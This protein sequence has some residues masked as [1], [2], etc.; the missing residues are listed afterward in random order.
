MTTVIDTPIQPVRG[1]RDHTDYDAAEVRLASNGEF[2]SSIL[3]APQRLHYVSRDKLHTV[4]LPSP[5]GDSRNEAGYDVATVSLGIQAIHQAYAAHIALNLRPDTLWY[6]I[7]HEVAEHVRQNADRYERLFTD[8]PGAKQTITVRDDSLSYDGPSD[9]QRSIKL[10]REPLAAKISDERLNL[11]V[12]TFS[13]STI[14][15]E[16]ALLVALMDTV[17]PYYDFRWETRCGIPQIRL[18]GEPTDWW[19]LHRRAEQLARE[20]GGL[21]GYFKDLMPVL[22]EI[23]QTAGGTEPDQAFWRALYKQDGGSGG[24]YVTGWITAFFAHIQTRD[25]AKPKETFDWRQFENGWGGYK[26]NHF[27]SHVTRVPFVWNYL[28]TEI[29]MAFV[30]GITGVDFDDDFLAP[31]L[32]FAVAE[33]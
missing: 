22:T 9:W 6:F 5:F 1:V 17:S 26:S 11:F 33:V 24:P 13:T 21:D 27:P 19:E 25:G 16:T 18:E 14:E 4:H 12:P 31:R 29:D 2:L 8:T 23:A 32:G 10:V 28:G 30:A 7:V 20:F 15:D 3:G